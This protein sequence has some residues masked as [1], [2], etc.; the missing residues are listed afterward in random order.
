MKAAPDEVQAAFDLHEAQRPKRVELPPLR[1]E[2]GPY[3]PPQV[4]VGQ[5]IK[6][7]RFGEVKVSSWS[8][9]PIPWP[10]CRIKGSSGSIILCGDLAR[11]VQTETAAA[12]A[13]AWGVDRFTVHKW[14]RVL[15]VKRANEGTRARHRQNRPLVISAEANE[16]GITRAH[17]APARVQA[18]K[19][20]RERGHISNRRA[21]S[22]EEV[23][24]LGTMPD[25][26]VA[27]RLG[28]CERSVSSER[29]RRGLAASKGY[30]RPDRFPLDGAALR[31]FRLE[32]RFTGGELGAVVGVNQAR[33]VET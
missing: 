7:E 31:R 20:K 24:M 17:A 26:E 28:C 16:L 4:Q 3:C 29:R 22:E 27:Q 21:W 6:C 8:D 32:R 5:L 2:N 10:L 19:T 1:F 23:A 30:S 14:R 12:V 33:V 13:L 9:A 25:K 18:E 15:N 11:A